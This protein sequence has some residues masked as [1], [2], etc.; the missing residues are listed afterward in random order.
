MT[1]TAPSAFSFL[2]QTWQSR[3]HEA[4]SAG[5]NL[6]ALAV[7]VARKGPY[8]ISFV[9]AAVE[10]KRQAAF[11][12]LPRLRAFP[13]I[14]TSARRIQ[15][16]DREVEVLMKLENPRIVLLGNVLSDEECD[17]LAAYGNERVVPSAIV[18]VEDYKSPYPRR[19]SQSAFVQTTE[20]VGRINKRL[21]AL[22]DWPVERGEMLQVVRY[23]VG[24]EYER[25]IDWFQPGSHEPTL[26][27]C[28]Q[29]LATFFVYLNEVELGGNTIFTEIG[30]EITPKKGSALFFANTDRHGTPDEKTWHAGMPVLK[31]VKFGA[32]KWLRARRCY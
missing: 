9:R 31:G 20:L 14:D 2:A 28:G 3:I 30:L 6:E 1:T 8:D 13:D 21:A 25:H 32:N 27:R 4:L 19:T 15:T 22:A 7:E 29:R 24:N 16:P 11:S 5:G 23:Q 18:P 17:A 26:E 10:E 12:H